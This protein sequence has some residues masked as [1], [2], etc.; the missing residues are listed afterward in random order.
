MIVIGGENLIDLVSSSFNSEGLPIYLA[1]PGGS[2]YNVAIAT[3]KLGAK[4]SYLTPLSKDT[5]GKLLSSKLKESGVKILSK[6]ISNPTSLAVVSIRNGIPS[7]SFHRNETAE[8]KVNLENLLDILPI[9]A[10]IFHVGSLGLIE[11]QDAEVW[12][13]FFKICKQKGLITSLDP[14]VRPILIQDRKNYIKR[15]ERMFFDVDIL[16]LSNEDLQWIYPSKSLNQSFKILKSKTNAQLL[17]LTLGEKGS[18]G[19]TSNFE[20]KI[21]SKKNF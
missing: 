16:K 4:V 2:P 15:L 11:G 19:K 18:I 7:Y 8:R 1:N 20:I 9:N 10:K 5:L 12:E 13:K 21:S 6:S 3:S 17:I 14:N